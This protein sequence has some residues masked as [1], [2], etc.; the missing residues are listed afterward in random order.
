MRLVADKT[1]TLRL[2]ICARLKHVNCERHE[3]LLFPK[4]VE[5]A[6]AAE[7]VHAKCVRCDLLCE[8]PVALVRA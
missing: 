6:P 8:R 7:G 5:V 4:A 2:V 3:G 1:V